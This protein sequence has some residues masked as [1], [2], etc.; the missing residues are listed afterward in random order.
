[1][2]FGPISLDDADGAIL[3]HSVAAGGRNWRKAHLLAAD[4]ISA[5]KAAGLTEIVAA[6][7]EPGDLSEDE[8]AA[9]LGAALDNASIE[10]RPASTGRVNLHARNAGVFTVSKSAVDAINAIDP[11]IT[12]ATLP[13]YAAVEAGQMLATV[14]IIPF[15][16]AEALLDRAVT[17]AA[18]VDLLTLHTFRPLT[19]GLV[20]TVL[21]SIK[22]SVLDKTR[23]LT[24]R[25]LVRA[26]GS[27]AR[28]MRT[29]HR[30]EDVAQA[31]REM[32]GSSDL[33]IVFGASAVSDASDVIPAAIR[34][35]GGTVERVGMPVD[36]GNLLVVG[37][38]D[39]KRVIGAPGCAR[40]PKLNGFDWVLDRLMAG[41]DVTDRDIA[42]MGVGGL[43]ME[44]E[45]RPQPR[46]PKARRRPAVDVVLLAAGR[47]Q[48][49]GG[50]NKLMAEFDGTPL[51]RRAADMLV[52]TKAR[53]THVVVGHQAD[54]IAEAL[55]RARV[56]IVQNPL[57]AD[58][59]AGSL[60]A[61]I[62][63]LRTDADGALIALADM[64]GVGQQDIDRLIDAFVGA[65]G[66]TIVR[67]THAGKRGNPVVLPSALFSAVAALEGDTGARHIIE[68]SDLPV[69][70]VEIGEAASLDVDTPEAMAR[71]G[72]QLVG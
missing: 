66:A 28:E 34:L 41:I 51:V 48:R 33:V 22:D 50:P 24:E 58:G 18:G 69:V 26:G 62:A 63:S 45:T 1:M 17:I 6:R 21:P 47:A 38:F 30:T 60:K 46:E 29:P 23:E 44:I 7:M 39:G 42:A 16:V 19:V 55:A 70:D 67:A 64:P 49:M 72:G 27:I 56:T 3:A 35:A 57:F 65:G 2:K 68:T 43:L 32:G 71:A 8:A 10:I 12:L 52:S 61:G 14:K 37:A 13:D 36:P 20:Q 25:R 4:D 5:M 59:L 9:R 11:S 31:I 54:R 53:A 15:A 40:S